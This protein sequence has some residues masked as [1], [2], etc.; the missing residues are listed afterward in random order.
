MRIATLVV[1]G[2]VLS[3]A[4]CSATAGRGAESL[5]LDEA[6]ALVS[7]KI[8][9]IESVYFEYTRQFDDGPTQRCQFAREGAKWRY[10][11][12]R[13]D[14]AEEIQQVSCCDGM[15]M[16]LFSIERKDTG[17]EK[18]GG[19]QI[20]DPKA[21][22]TTTPECLVGRVHNLQRS[23]PDILALPGATLDS[24]V[25]KDLQ[26]TVH[27]VLSS[28]EKNKTKYDVRLIFDQS[29]GMAMRETL[30]TESP[31]TVTWPGW[32]AQWN[33]L[34]YKYVMDEK[35]KTPRW[36]PV[37][38]LLTQ[39]AG[40]P[41]RLEKPPKMKIVISEICLNRELAPSLFRPDFPKAVAFH[42]VTSS[43]DGQSV[44]PG[45]KPRPRAVKPND[46]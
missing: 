28:S 9:S 22:E 20:H 10:V 30:V 24:Q 1:T 37:E 18:W 42:D 7:E 19:V 25:G 46:R 6:R 34:S 32:K 29:H 40:L 16:F 2:A 26:I 39:G 36:C 43:G 44:I 45:N 12:L 35:S 5:T 3:L 33:V 27:D 8:N 31:K 4:P 21:I 17:E 41:G 23:I 14:D 13:G 15:F 11:E 38:G